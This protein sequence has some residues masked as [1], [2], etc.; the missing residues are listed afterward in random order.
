MGKIS[1]NGT[2][3][4]L[5]LAFVFILLVLLASPLRR[6]L[7]AG[8]Q[9][10]GLKLGIN[11]NNIAQGTYVDWIKSQ[12]D[13]FDSDQDVTF[14]SR[15][16]AFADRIAQTPTD[17]LGEATSPKGEKWIEVDIS[18]Q[19]LRMKEGQTTVGDFLV[20]TG[21]WA[22]TPTGEWRIWIK[23]RYTR[24]RGGSKALGTYYDLPNVPYVMYYYQGYGVHGAYWHNNFGHPMSHG[25]TNMKPEEAGIVFNWANVG[26]RVVVHQ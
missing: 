13:D 22:P 17:I 9:A 24:M 18:E 25:C 6:Y 2:G 19:K 21:K 10:A 12:P 26:T 7:Y 4:L 11:L 8:Y 23:L 20:S 16:V 5:I 3:Q 15:K 1:K 14:L